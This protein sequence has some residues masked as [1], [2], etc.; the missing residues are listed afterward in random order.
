[1]TSMHPAAMAANRSYD[2]LK[3]RIKY[4]F[5]A[6]KKKDRRRFKDF[7]VMSCMKKF[8]EYDSV[9]TLFGT[10]EASAPIG[11]LFTKSEGRFY[12]TLKADGTHKEGST[13]FPTSFKSKF[14]LNKDCNRFANAINQSERFY[15]PHQ[16]DEGYKFRNILQQ[17]AGTSPKNTDYNFGFT[18]EIE[19]YPY[20]MNKYAKLNPICKATSQKDYDAM[21]SQYKPNTPPAGAGKKASAQ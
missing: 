19:V 12:V 17:G 7:D 1:M 13:Y 16:D 8:S 21:E 5:P 9:E 20:L 6:K 4:N 10:A 11:K 18:N 3:Y 2:H 14:K 15:P